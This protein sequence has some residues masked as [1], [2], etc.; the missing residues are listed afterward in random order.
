MVFGIGYHLLLVLVILFMCVLISV[1]EFAYPFNFL[2]KY[3]FW[4]KQNFCNVVK[5]ATFSRVKMVQNW[6]IYRKRS[7]YHRFSSINMASISS[8]YKSKQDR[9]N[10]LHKK[11]ESPRILKTKVNF[12]PKLKCLGINLDR[13]LLWNPH[14]TNKIKKAYCHMNN[15]VEP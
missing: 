11:E 8:V 2:S 12:S 5:A 4:W 14:L 10:P 9:D 1:K 7:F 15:A 13:K 6:K 3:F